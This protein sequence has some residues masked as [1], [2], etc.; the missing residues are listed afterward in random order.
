[1]FQVPNVGHVCF[2]HNQ[3]TTIVESL[4]KA[5]CQ[6]ELLNE[7]TEKD[8]DVSTSRKLREYVESLPEMS[9]YSSFWPPLTSKRIDALYQALASSC[10]LR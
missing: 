6:L 2:H 5:V 1:M 4:L 8:P 10:S 9:T 3:G 7:L